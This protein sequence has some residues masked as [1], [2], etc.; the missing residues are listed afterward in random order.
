MQYSHQCSLSRQIENSGQIPVFL[1]HSLLHIGDSSQF[2][3]KPMHIKGIL[4]YCVKRAL[5]RSRQ[6]LVDAV[7]LRIYSRM[8]RIQKI[9]LLGI[10][11]GLYHWGYLF[12]L[13]ILGLNPNSLF[14]K[15]P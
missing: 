6:W 15:R 14:H 4:G 5:S 10:S 7:R 12:G 9:R 2:S 3:G 8:V 11:T 13:G 1:F